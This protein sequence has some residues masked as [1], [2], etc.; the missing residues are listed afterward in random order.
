MLGAENIRSTGGS[1]VEK[2]SAA[3]FRFMPF[4]LFLPS[5]AST[6]SYCFPDAVFPSTPLPDHTSTSAELHRAALYSRPHVLSRVRVIPIVLMWCGCI[7]RL[8]GFNLGKYCKPPGLTM[9][10][11]SSKTWEESRY[12]EVFPLLILHPSVF[13]RDIAEYLSHVI[14]R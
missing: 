10:Q 8:V 7:D 2:S 14:H 12:T 13:A 5:Q 6:S 3:K 9:G 11:N 1:L 4:D